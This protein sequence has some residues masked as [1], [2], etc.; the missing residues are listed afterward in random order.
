ME[1]IVFLLW[2]EGPLILLKPWVPF[3][4]P[5]LS[6]LQG[7]HMHA[8]SFTELRGT[9]AHP[10]RRLHS[11]VSFIRYVCSQQSGQYHF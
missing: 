4:D 10:L 2:G 1:I 7:A 3:E 6:P 11:L 8:V 9:G 5:R